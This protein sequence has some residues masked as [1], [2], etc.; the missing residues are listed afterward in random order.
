MKQYQ[1]L[2]I[3]HLEHMDPEILCWIIEF[4]YTDNVSAP[5]YKLLD[6]LH[7]AEYFQ[8]ERLKA[9]IAVKITTMT[10]GFDLDSSWKSYAPPGT[11][12]SSRSKNGVSVHCIQ[13]RPN[14]RRQ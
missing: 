13:C 2:P 1:G 11:W 5:D 6:M 7:A 3:L 10:D 14:I 12:K 8:I 4:I 9:Q